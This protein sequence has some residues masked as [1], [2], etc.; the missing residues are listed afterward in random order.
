MIPESRWLQTS[1]VSAKL[2]VISLW[3]TELGG[4]YNG[5]LE[6]ATHGQLPLKGKD[7]N[8]CSSMWK[9]GHAFP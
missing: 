1:E 9:S 8:Q 4:C 5:K 7:E 2:N 6:N 3:P